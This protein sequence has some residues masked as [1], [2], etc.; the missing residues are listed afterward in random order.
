MKSFYN[1]FLALF[2]TLCLL[3]SINM[4]G[5][6]L[7]SN[8]GFESGELAPWF[9]DN[10][11]TVTIGTDA[12][13][14]EYAAVGN[15][16]QNVDLEMGVEYE[17]RCKAKIITVTG[18]E[19]IWIGVRGPS[20]LVQNSRVFETEWEDMSIDFAAP[21]TGAHKIWIWGQGASSYAS[22]GWTLVVKGTSGINDQEAKDKIKITNRANGVSVDMM[23]V[24]SDAQIIVHDLAGRQ[25]YRTTTPDNNTLIEKTAFPTAGI[26]VVSVM[27]EKLHRVEK[28]AVLK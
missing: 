20:A 22:D 13:E 19:K 8:P 15:A 28:V 23:D 24:F 7:L 9:G 16:A 1:Q 17:L 6:N 5:Q 3:A 11:N 25:L 26:Y 4:N 12:A 21:E 2:T 10:D 14:G 27:T 18:D